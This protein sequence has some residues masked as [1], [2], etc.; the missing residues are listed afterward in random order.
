M[1][2][3]QVALQRSETINWIEHDK[4][5]LAYLTRVTVLVVEGCERLLNCIPS[6]MLHRLQHLKQLKVRE[7]GSLVEI[8]ESDGVDANE[9]E[10][11]AMK[12][13]DYNLQEM[14]L[15]S[16]PKLV[17]IWKKH[18]GVIGF[19]NLKRLNIGCCDGLKSV[20]P[21]PIA[22]SLL[23]LQEL[24][25]YECEM[26]EEIV[27]K[28]EEKISE[29]RNKVKIIFPALQWLTLYRLPNLE[30]F[31]SSNYQIEMPSCRDITIKEC[32][33]METCCYGTVSTLNMSS[34][35]RIG[36]LKPQEEPC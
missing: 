13:Y 5:L 31:C 16:L 29:E 30:C 18:G 35:I 14:Y 22:R 26:I 11:D 8:F 7:C 15:H 17:H 28:E 25:V 6:N 36:Y 32:S 1:Y 33:K 21:H 34:S 9:D 3:L 10:E 23:Q 27:T 12:L 2:L 20:L 24:S 19:Q 4:S